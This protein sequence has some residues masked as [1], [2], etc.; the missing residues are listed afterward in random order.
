MDALDG[1]Y[2]SSGE[3]A[4]PEFNV[5][6]TGLDQLNI[7][8]IKEAKLG[9]EFVASNGTTIEKLVAQVNNELWSD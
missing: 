6:I 7:D 3:V 1:L 4:N 5:I 2:N 8:N 9:F